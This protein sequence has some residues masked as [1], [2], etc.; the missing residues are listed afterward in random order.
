[1]KSGRPW[2]VLSDQKLV[3]R[4]WLRIRE[5]RVRLPN[6]HTIDEFHLIEG[7]D[8]ASVLALTDDGNAVLVRQYRHGAGVDSLELPAGVIEPGEAG[9]VAAERELLEE[10][11]YRAASLHP[12]LTV[13]TEPAR[14][15]TRAHLFVATG[16][17]SAGPPRPEASE[18]LELV[19]I[20]ARE[21]AA[22]IDSGEIRHG[23]HVGAILLAARR[24]FLSLD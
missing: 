6:G 20:P 11:G 23:V 14:H 17:W 13:D 12:L 24:G 22:R 19:V 18:Q 9:A 5:Q 15:T 21:L 16:A 1:M 7:P 4:R 10:T 8:W 3:D 2:E